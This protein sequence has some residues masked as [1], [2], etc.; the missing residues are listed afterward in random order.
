MYRI[1]SSTLLRSSYYGA[2]AITAS[3]F[4]SNNYKGNSVCQPLRSTTTDADIKQIE[5]ISTNPL[6]KKGSLPLFTEIKSEHI[7]PA[8]QEDLKTLKSNFQDFEAILLNPQMGEAWGQRRVEYDYPS[9]VE[10][11]EQMQF[12]LSYSWGVVGHL[13]G[14]KNSDDLR[15]A[16]DTIQP[17]VIEVHQKMGQ[18]QALFNAMTALKK[19]NSIWQD[20]DETQKRIV[21]SAIRQ[22]ESSGV[23]LKPEL[24]EKFNQLQLEAAELSTKFSNNV[25]DST[26]LFK[27]E[28][29]NPA[30]V[31]G[32]PLSAKALAAQTANAS[33]EV[34][35]ATAEN[36]PWVITLDMPSYLPAMQHLKSREI[37]EKLYRAYVMRASSGE[38]DNAPIIQRTLQIKAEMAAMLG[39]KSFAE[40]SLSS[41]MAPS[42]DSVLELISMLQTKSLPAAQRDLTELTDFAHSKGLTGPLQLWDVP[43][44]SE[45][46][47]EDL[48]Q[49]EEEELRA[50]FPLPTVLKGLFSLANR[51]FGITIE[52]A[53]GQTQVWHPDVQFFNIKDDKTGEYIASF[54][55]DPY[56][57]P[58]D[59]RGG[60]WMDVCVGKSKV[61]Q[62][63]PVAYLT[64]NGSPPV[65]E[66]PSLMTFRE[67]ETL[68]HEFGHGLQHMLTR[69]EHGDAAGI[70]NVEWDAVEL[71]S[72]F[73]ENW[74]YDKPTLY[75]FA[76]HF[77]T[78]QP[79]P[80]ELFEK[81]KAAK[82]FQAGL[83]M[84]RQLFFGAMDMRLHSELYDPFGTQTPFEVQHELAKQFTVIAPLPEDRFLCSFGHIFAGG[85]SAGYYSYKWAEVMS[86]DA[87]G[88]FEDVG[89][90]NETA[91]QSTG[92]KFR[93]TVLAMGGG[94][95]PSDVFRDFR[96]RDPSP[97][98][99]LRHS[100]LLVD[101][102]AGKK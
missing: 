89:L 27:L 71:P 40:K 53:D 58:A 55:L 39:Y 2:G 17:S 94:R 99:L 34:K 90:D 92:R 10:K 50:Y 33:S 102:T 52:A 70:N 73:M 36:G 54:F 19:R 28:L 16:H 37:R 62:R 83:A 64:C 48:Y 74:C 30:D 82:N 1:K 56:S 69:V 9:V 79:L 49:Y 20:L 97:E 61:M 86:A 76:K 95:H 26:K 5:D 96:G 93:E 51:L 78:G 15:K 80:H 8:V 72:Q 68:F 21:N 57:R 12:P 31:E 59:K 60:A 24:R 98:A 84:L 22:M 63:L 45:R 42:V 25:L 35:T 29:T 4:S 41:K 44:W 87:F 66:Q 3:L 23:G 14:V 67:V 88:A 81:I 13:M 85:Y 46:L 91:V 75:G 11:L 100:G 38:H 7:L 32:L 65:G 18:S 47:R 77:Q 43:Y 101:A 6:M